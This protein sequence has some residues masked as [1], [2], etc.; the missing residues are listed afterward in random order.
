MSFLLGAIPLIKTI[1]SAINAVKS[2]I[3][4]SKSLIAPSCTSKVTDI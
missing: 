4:T 1:G 3:T 2:I